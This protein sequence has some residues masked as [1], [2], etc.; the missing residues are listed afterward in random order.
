MLSG[1][2]VIVTRPAAQSHAVARMIEAIGG[3]AILFPALE[4]S[5]HQPAAQSRAALAEADIAIFISANAVAFGL[6]YAKE[7]LLKNLQ[8]AAIGNATA[9]ALKNQGYG[10]I[11]VP[12]SGADSEA[13]LATAA[14]QAVAGKEIVIF[15]GVG[16]RETLRSAL[17]QRGA[18]VA[19]I[20]CYARRQP[21]VS[22]SDLAKLL[23]HEDIAAIHVLSRETLQNF[24]NMIGPNALQ[25]LRH[26][27]LF[28]PH[29]AILEGARVLGFG[30]GVLTG[31]GGTSR[32]TKN[33]T[34]SGGVFMV[35]GA[36]FEPATFGL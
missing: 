13:L 23:H 36:G 27:P 26:K 1:T 25:T 11:I 29:P 30:E 28:A 19:Y 31:F 3:R 7:N 18:K 32:I 33:P 5:A 17:C 9:Q 24:S 16:G 6:R 22:A 2:G 15:R 12:E 4:I 21:D 34:V 20:E 10:D 35:A 14:L 8:L